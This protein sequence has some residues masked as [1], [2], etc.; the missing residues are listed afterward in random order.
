MFLLA[1]MAT[2][3]AAETFLYGT[4]CSPDDGGLSSEDACRSAAGDNGINYKHP[5]GGEWH[6]GCIVHSGAS[7]SYFPGTY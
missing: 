6:S 2:T 3:T 7:L 4:W 1:A 5:A